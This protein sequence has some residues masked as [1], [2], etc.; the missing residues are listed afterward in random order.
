MRCRGCGTE[1]EPK[2]PKGRYCSDR[3]RLAAWKQ[4]KAQAQADREGRVRM[5]AEEI[6]RVLG[7]QERKG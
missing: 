6:L 5:L 1:F 4:G 7:G 2:H 3:C